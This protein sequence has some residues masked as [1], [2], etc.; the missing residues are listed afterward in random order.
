MRIGCKCRTWTA[1]KLEKRL[2]L[3]GGFYLCEDCGKLIEE[4]NEWR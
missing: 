4:V 3:S 1:N 2:I